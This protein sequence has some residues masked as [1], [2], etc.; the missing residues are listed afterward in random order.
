MIPP[1][2]LGPLGYQ[3]GGNWF[4]QNCILKNKLNINIL[5]ITDSSVHNLGSSFYLNL[6][7]LFRVRFKMLN[8]FRVLPLKIKHWIKVQVGCLGFGFIIHIRTQLVWPWL[9]TFFCFVCFCFLCLSFFCCCYKKGKGKLLAMLLL[10]AFCCAIAFVAFKRSSPYQCCFWASL[11][12]CCFWASSSCCFWAIVVVC[13][14]WSCCWH[15]VEL[16]LVQGGAIG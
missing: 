1:S 8:E 10:G 12:C 11:L 2:P 7:Q 13:M 5:E 3:F 14:R 6:G 4:L 9:G 16:L 15:K